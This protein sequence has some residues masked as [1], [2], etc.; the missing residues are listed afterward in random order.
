M[1]LKHL[2]RI[3]PE[4]EYSLRQE[5]LFRLYYPTFLQS[6]DWF[7]NDKPEFAT[8]KFL[9]Q[10]CLTAISSL[11]VSPQTFDKFAETD[12]LT[13]VYGLVDNPAFMKSSCLLLEV[14]VIMEMQKIEENDEDPYIGTITTAMFEFLETETENLLMALEGDVEPE[15]EDNLVNYKS[16][17]YKASGIWRAAAGIVLCTPRFRKIFAE[18]QIFERANKLCQL[19]AIAIATNKINGS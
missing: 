2:L 14:C 8:I 9:I 11:I 13:K 5:L 19:L 15:N 16:A 18:H 1:I 4:A 12:A 10:S 17:F 3:T 7:K 6:V